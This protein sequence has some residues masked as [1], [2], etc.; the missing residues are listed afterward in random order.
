MVTGRSV[1][2]SG[3]ARPVTM[4]D[5]PLPGLDLAH[6]TEAVVRRVDVEDLRLRRDEVGRGLEELL[7]V[8]LLDVRRA[9]VGVTEAL[10]A[11]EL[12]LVGEA[13]GE[14]EEQAAL[15]GV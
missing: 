7:H 11:D 8:R 14:L 13:A 6:R 2:L 12:V 15:L 4:I 3:T 10:D 1:P 5:G 9:R